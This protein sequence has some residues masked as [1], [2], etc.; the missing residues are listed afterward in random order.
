M[1]RCGGE[2]LGDAFAE[3]ATGL[4]GAYFDSAAE[5][6]DGGETGAAAVPSPPPLI[7]ER[8]DADVRLRRLADI[9]R[10]V[11]AAFHHSRSKRLLTRALF[12][13]LPYAHADVVRTLED[14]EKQ[15]VYVIRRTEE[16]NDWLFLTE[17]G[18]GVEDSRYPDSR[19]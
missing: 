18:A 5:G 2:G 9:E 17:S 12:D 8:V 15:G 16:G 3:W 10:D 7:G 19:R 13:A 4:S 6:D 11:L 1:D 14:L